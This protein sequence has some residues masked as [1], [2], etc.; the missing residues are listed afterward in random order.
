MAVQWTQYQAFITGFIDY[1]CASGVMAC[2]S[3]TPEHPSF[4]HSYRMTGIVTGRS[5]HYYR[6]CT[7]AEAC[8]AARLVWCIWYVV[9]VARPNIKQSMNQVH[10]SVFQSRP[11]HGSTLQAEIWSPCDFFTPQAVSCVP[12]TIV[13]ECEEA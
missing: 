5:R 7:I 3:W 12:V 9:D 4:L 1:C 11:H 2:W 6:T 13:L 10:V 8:T